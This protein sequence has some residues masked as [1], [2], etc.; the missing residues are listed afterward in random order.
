MRL[1][2][3][4]KPGR[5]DPGLRD[6]GVGVLK[7]SAM[8]VGQGVEVVRIRADADKLVRHLAVLED[9]HGGDRGDAKLGSEL[10]ILVD[11]ELANL[12]PF[13]KVLSEFLDGG[14]ECPAWAAPWGPEIDERGGVRIYELREVGLV[15]LMNSL[16]FHIESS[17][18]CGSWVIGRLTERENK[19]TDRSIS[20]KSTFYMVVGSMGAKPEEQARS[21]RI[22]AIWRA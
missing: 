10:G 15:D 1:E 6:S 3:T 5:T 20:Y 8:S 16:G 11:V 4:K 17:T 9:Q 22:S 2:R 14:P 13:T 7:Q 18:G 19:E 21:S 12:G